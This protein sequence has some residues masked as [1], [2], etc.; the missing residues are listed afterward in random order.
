[1]TST[2]WVLMQKYKTEKYDQWWYAYSFNSSSLY[3]G[4]RFFLDNPCQSTDNHAIIEYIEEIVTRYIIHIW[5]SKIAELSLFLSFS[6]HICNNS[7]TRT[8][9]YIDLST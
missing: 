4:S 7:H 6:R 3:R 1:M 8:Y 5:N 9:T 2:L